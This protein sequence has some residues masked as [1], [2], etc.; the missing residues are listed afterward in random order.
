MSIILAILLQSATVQAT[1]TPNGPSCHA[2]K[3]ANTKLTKALQRTPSPFGLAVGTGSDW[4]SELLIVKSSHSVGVPGIPTQ[5][6]STTTTYYQAVNDRICEK[7][8]TS[9]NCPS[10]ED[11][12]TTL[13]SRSYAILHNRS[14]L[15]GGFAYHPPSAF[16]HATDGDGNV[17][18]IS[19][20]WSGHPLMADTSQFF[21]SIKACTAEIEAMLHER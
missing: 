17:T 20:L 9:K 3:D 5:R 18:R 2:G 12:V 21:R 11:A 19:A 4:G 6:R 1:G 15:R 8:L 16:V 10:L 13:Q 7:E 14:E